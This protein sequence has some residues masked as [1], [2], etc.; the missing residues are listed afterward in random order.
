MN[1]II[2]TSILSLSL[3][4][5]AHAQNAASLAVGLSI[6]E[7]MLATGL[8]VNSGQIIAA[9]ARAT[10]L[11]ATSATRIAAGAVT[12]ARSPTMLAIGG[13]LVV[14]VLLSSSSPNGPSFSMNNDGTVTTIRYKLV[15]DSPSYTGPAFKTGDNLYCSYDSLCYPSIGPFLKSAEAWLSSRDGAQFDLGSGSYSLSNCVGYGNYIGC[16]VTN[17][18]NGQVYLFS[19]PNNSHVA[20]FR[21]STPQ[22][23][24]CPADSYLTYDGKCAALTPPPPSPNDP[25]QAGTPESKTHT[26]ES[27]VQD[28]TQD[29]KNQV[30][31]PATIANFA[32]AIANQINQ[33]PT[34]SGPPIPIV[35]GEHVIKGNGGNA[36]SLP[37]IGNFT[38]PISKPDDV[39]YDPI[40]PPSPIAGTGP[41]TGTLPGTGSTVN[42]GESTTNPEAQ[43][44]DLGTDP[45]I[46][47]PNP[48]LE[49][50][51]TAAAILNPLMNIMPDIKSL[52]ITGKGGACPTPEFSV[53]GNNLRLDSQCVLLEQNRT[54]L[55]AI[56]LVMF[57][58]ISVRIVLEA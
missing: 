22:G 28:L 27:A 3:I 7:A 31:T 24:N 14:G 47:T 10:A 26:F 55:Q 29:E 46:G 17:S 25:P 13:M 35:T 4:G 34:Y 51:P 32:N 16:D 18:A 9:Q 38:Q 37:T 30:V 58:L 48:V 6:R 2:L 19:P 52:K 49:A 21:Y 20:G 1:K 56:M 5:S 8:S 36:G 45:G 50:T 41:V 53:F 40:N 42:P 33:D 43:P 54:T 12:F 39:K 57:G 11:M 23:I 15:N 44:V